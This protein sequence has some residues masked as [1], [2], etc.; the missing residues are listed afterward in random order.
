MSTIGQAIEG[1]SLEVQSTALK[2]AGAEAIYSDAYTGT[3]IDRPEFDKL[4]EGVGSG[5][6]V[7]VTKLDRVA[8]SVKQGLEIINDLIERGV[9]INILNMGVIDNTS[10]QGKLMLTVMLAFA[11]FERDMI[12]ERTAEGKAIKRSKGQKAEGRY[13]LVLDNDELKRLLNEQQAGSIKVDDAIR[14]LK[15]CRTSWYKYTKEMRG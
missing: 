2:N 3:T 6:T 5:D 4:I 11:E 9:K 13:A 1:N 7:V 15:I 12:I 10:P 14:R 8:R